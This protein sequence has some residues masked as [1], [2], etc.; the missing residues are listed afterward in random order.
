MTTNRIK[1]GDASIARVS[2]EWKKEIKDY[3][4]NMYYLY[5]NILSE[6]DIIDRCCTIAG[7]KEANKRMK[8]ELKR[9]NIY[10]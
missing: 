3:Q 2:L 7:L 9:L 4:K 8:E 10:E 5:Q 6:R 1:K